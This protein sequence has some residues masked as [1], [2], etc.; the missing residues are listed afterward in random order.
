MSQAIVIPRQTDNSYTRP[1]TK[2][3]NR[4]DNTNFTTTAWIMPYKEDRICVSKVMKLKTNK[5]DNDK[6]WK[7][8]H[9]IAWLDMVNQ[10]HN[11]K[12]NMYNYILCVQEVVT[13]LYIVSYYIKWV[14]TSWTHSTV[15]YWQFFLVQVFRHGQNFLWHTVGSSLSNSCQ[16]EN[17]Y[18]IYF[19][20]FLIRLMY[21]IIILLR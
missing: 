1:Q 16:F 20:K 13:H 9:F 10:I 2:W 18:W 4:S 17:T 11:S 8:F 3:L 7:Y 12:K 19:G 15:E 14:T 21:M 5:I 6:C